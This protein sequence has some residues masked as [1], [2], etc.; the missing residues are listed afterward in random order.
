MNRVIGSYVLIGYRYGDKEKHSYV[1]GI[2]AGI[3]TA[4]EKAEEETILR[5]G[6]YSVVIYAQREDTGD[7]EEV[8]E[9][10][11]PNQYI[12]GVYHDRRK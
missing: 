4:I 7:V 11:I 3:D 6:K 8:Y 10:K 2:Y 1:I 12:Q 9:T 5:G